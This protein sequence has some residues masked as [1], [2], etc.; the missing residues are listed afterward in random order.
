MKG[1]L[2]LFQAAIL[3]WRALHPYNSVH[4]V[5]VWEPLEAVRLEA[6]LRAQLE[7]L[8]ITG[9]ELD[10]RRRRY[11]WHG[12]PATPGLRVI[13]AASDSLAALSR[14]SERELNAGFAADG[15]LEPFRFFALEDGEGFYLGL[16]YDHWVAGG[17]SIVGLLH[18]LVTCYLQG[19]GQTASDGV[20]ARRYGPTYARLLRRQFPACV[21]ALWGLP[22][23]AASCRRAFRPRYAAPQDGYNAV[24]FTRIGA[25][26]RARLDACAS[27]WGITSHDL[28]LAIVLK[29][30]SPLTMRRL[31]SP[32]RNEIAVASIVNIRRDLGEEASAA[33]APYLASF[34][35]SHRTPDDM[36]LRDLAAAINGQTSEIKQRKRYLQTLLAMGI[37]GFE[38]R[39]MSPLQRQRFF[40]K[41][42]P[43]CAGTTPLSVDPLWNGGAG[44]APGLDYLRAVSTG[45]LSPMVLAFTMV[46]DV[47]NVGIT[48]RTTVFRRDAVE[49]IAAAML[50]SIRT[51]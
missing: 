35:V 12:G 50:Q 11:E 2:N 13:A 34:R 3:R 51:L 17:D 33:L 29:G 4:A 44:R 43:V 42:Y 32:T 30:L 28:L 47:I 27:A 6:A 24:S 14:E 23:L 48:F 39:F 49:G 15:R 38:W 16:A 41:H 37:A 18:G 26:D 21:N 9:L 10:A 40:A 5:R 46:G 31:Q 25:A 36:P 45:P 1:R 22:R 19:P 7:L 8:G 20:S